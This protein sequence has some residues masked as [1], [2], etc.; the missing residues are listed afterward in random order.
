MDRVNPGQ[1]R[2]HGPGAIDHVRK[3]QGDCIGHAT[4]AM[5][6][7]HIR[8]RPEDDV[9]GRFRLP[10]PAQQLQICQ[11]HSTELDRP[12]VLHLAD[13]QHPPILR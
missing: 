10:R 1:M 13:D 4:L 6:G 8:M 7:L 2:R 5:P 12:V 9:G 11:A 3:R